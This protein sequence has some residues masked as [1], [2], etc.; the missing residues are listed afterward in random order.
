MSDD[1]GRYLHYHEM[2]AGAQRL[3]RA[4]FQDVRPRSWG[5]QGSAGPW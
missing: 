5:V 2:S 3:K 4:A 1:G